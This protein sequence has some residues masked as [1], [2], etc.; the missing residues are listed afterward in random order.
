I[1]KYHILSINGVRLD[2]GDPYALLWETPPETA[3]VVWTFGHKWQD[4]PWLDNR[5]REA[6]SA[7]PWSVYEVHTGSWKKRADQGN[8]SLNYRELAAELVPYVV[9]MGFTHVELMPVMEHP[10]FPSWGYQ[11]T[12]QFAPTSR[13]GKPEDLMF[14]I[15]SFH[16]AG[17]G[18][19]L[20]WV[21]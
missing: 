7:K 14:L 9:E 5:Y 11:I 19:I 21:P 18:V 4:K 12:G 10:Y 20:D 1:Y 13:F 15:D 6:G 2:K 16:Q 8:R 3:S 17:I